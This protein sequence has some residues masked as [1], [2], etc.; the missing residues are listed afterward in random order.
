MKGGWHRIQLGKQVVW[1][2]LNYRGCIVLTDEPF[3]SDG[4][5]K[6]LVPINSDS[7][8]IQ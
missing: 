4:T 5:R 2:S 3:S 8:V 7:I 6:E 1:A